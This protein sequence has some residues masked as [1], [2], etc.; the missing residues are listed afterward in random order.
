MLLDMHDTAPDGL[1][2]AA[3]KYHDC[4]SI[5]SQQPLI[6]TLTCFNMHMSGPLRMHIAACNQDSGIN[7]QCGAAV[8]DTAPYLHAARCPSSDHEVVNTLEV[9]H[10]CQSAD[11]LEMVIRDHQCKRSS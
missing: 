10:C 9:T 5:R 8:G 6:S 7:I 11:M 1:T 3:Y 4:P 2:G